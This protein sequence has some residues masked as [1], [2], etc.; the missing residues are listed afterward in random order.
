[1]LEQ[2]LFYGGGFV[3]A[4]LLLVLA[5]YIKLRRET[6]P[7]NKAEL[8]K[9][10]DSFQFRRPGIEYTKADRFKDFNRV[11]GDESGRRVLSQII[12]KSEGKVIYEHEADTTGKLAYRAG[13]RYIGLWII[14]ILSHQPEIDN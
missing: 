11:F 13:S 9:M 8:Q 2:L 12:E 3:T 6:K 14:G 10:Y 5:L 7:F 1:M 4:C